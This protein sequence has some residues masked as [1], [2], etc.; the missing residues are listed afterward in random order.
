MK[1]AYHAVPTAICVF[2]FDQ[3]QFAKTAFTFLLSILLITTTVYSQKKVI[4]KKLDHFHFALS[5][6][7]TAMPYGSFSHLF[8]KE[9]H[10]G[11]EIGTGFN[12]T[13]KL[14]HD[15][16]QT[17]RLGYSYHEFVQ[18]TL[19]LYSEMGYRYKFPL[20]ISASASIGGGWMHSIQDAE[21]FSRR[22]MFRTFS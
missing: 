2:S 3:N 21:V 17:F 4:T 5:N 22:K 6:S 11:V 20:G 1:P 10:P 18:R 12:W 7:H 19:M 8:Y 15:W 14:K 13:V 9:F 16:F